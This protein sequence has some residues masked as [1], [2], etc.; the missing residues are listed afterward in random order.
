MWLTTSSEGWLSSLA[1]ESVISIHLKQVI[2]GITSTLLAFQG[3]L[4]FHCR[5][6]FLFFFCQQLLRQWVFSFFPWFPFLHIIVGLCRRYIV[7]II[8]FCWVYEIFLLAWPL[9]KVNFQSIDFILLALGSPFLLDESWI[10]CI[11]KHSLV[12]IWSDLCLGGS[13][14]FFLIVQLDK[15]QHCK[16]NILSITLEPLWWIFQLRQ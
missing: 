11:C 13:W 2:S 7:R 3:F 5:A 14:F 15:L 16:S 10:L 4:S 12:S 9:L 6:W 8:L 1:L